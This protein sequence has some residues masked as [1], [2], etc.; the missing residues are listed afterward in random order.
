MYYCTKCGSND[1]YKVSQAFSKSTQTINAKTAGGVIGVSSPG[2]VGIGVGGASTTGTIQ[3]IEGRALSPPKKPDNLAVGCTIYVFYFLFCSFILVPA[4]SVWTGASVSP[5][6]A[7]FLI[8]G[9][10]AVS[11]WTTNKTKSQLET[12]N[13]DL[14]EWNKKWTCNRCG[15]IF[16]PGE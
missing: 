5:L 12:Y 15:N 6:L 8:L 11:T 2:N 10:V 13:S 4:I 7:L 9:F 1:T 16:I 14:E 3:T